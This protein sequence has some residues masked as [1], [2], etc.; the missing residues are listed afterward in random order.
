M[1]GPLAGR[2]KRSNSAASP[3]PLHPTK[4]RFWSAAS[5]KL[6]HGS[7]PRSIAMARLSFPR[8]PDLRCPSCGP[9]RRYPKPDPGFW[10]RTSRHD[11]GRPAYERIVASLIEKRNDAPNLSITVVFFEVRRVERQLVSSCARK[12]MDDVVRVVNALLSE[13]GGDA[14]GFP[15]LTNGSVAEWLCFG[16]CRGGGVWFFLEVGWRIS[17]MLGS[18]P[19]CEGEHHQGPR[20]RCQPCQDLLRCD[21][22][23]QLVFSRFQAVLDRPSMA[24]DRHQRFDGRSRRAPGGERRR[25]RHR[26]YDARISRPRVHNII[27]T[28]ELLGLE[29]G[30]FEI[31]AGSG[32]LNKIRVR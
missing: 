26:R 27:S 15:G 22:A 6:F 20:D 12:T 9:S 7:R 30:Q 32:C 4:L 8:I 13:S 21:R 16:F 18:R 23:P 19:S 31:R 5:R 3:P 10:P 29:I 25:D 1:A 2:G 28:V 17:A 24:F 11:L 14:G